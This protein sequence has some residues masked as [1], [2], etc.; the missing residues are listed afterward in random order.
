MAFT[1]TR[2][3]AVLAGLALGLFLLAGMFGGLPGGA[4]AAS[5]TGD[6]L[7]LSVDGPI[8]PVVARYVEKGLEKAAREGC[9]ACIVELNTPG[10]LYDT[11]QEIVQSILNSRVP[12]VV[13]VHPAGGWAASAGTFITISGHVAAM[14]PGTR[15]GAAHPVGVQGEEIEGVPAEKITEDAAAWVRS[16]ASMRGRDADRAE[17][18]VVRSRSYTDEEALKYRLVDVRARDMSGLLTAVEGRQVKLIDGR[19]VTL[20]TAGADVEHLPMSGLERFLLTLADPNI[21]YMLLSL[22]MLGLMIEL[23]HPGILF[24]GVAGAVATI[25]GLYSLGTLDASWS[26]ILLIILAFGFFIAEVFVPSFGL[27]TVAGLVSLVTGSV[28]LF[29][30]SGPMTPLNWGVI[31]VVVA[32]VAA[33]MILVG[34]AV[35]RAHRRKAVTGAEGL[36]GAVGETIAALEPCGEILLEG[37]RWR[38]ESLEGA[39]PPGERVEVVR[40]EGLKVYVRRRDGRNTGGSG[41]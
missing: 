39:I 37:E 33:C 36:V 25:L 35:I 8:V 15:I 4:W 22:G 18:A 17:A 10:G 23:F 6:V 24:P 26:G 20:H 31:G 5:R 1:A 11:T 38:A 21:A 28:M 14:A 12:V 9:Q 29:T 27:L 3:R 34:R 7:V 30:E 41:G 2:V 19:E 32:A 13:Y 16:I 40:L